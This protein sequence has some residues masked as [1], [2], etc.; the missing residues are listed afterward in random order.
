MARL[1]TALLVVQVTEAARHVDEVRRDPAVNKAADQAWTD[2]KQASR[3]ISALA[4]ETRA[5]WAR[6]SGEHTIGS[7]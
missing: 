6:T 4:A 1:N 3:S 2:I 7:Q 5:A